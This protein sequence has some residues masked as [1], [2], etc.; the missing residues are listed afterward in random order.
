MRNA[1]LLD[2]KTNLIVAANIIQ[3]VTPDQ[4]VGVEESWRVYRD[5]AKSKRSREGVGLPEHNHWRW[6]EKALELKFTAYR[7][8]AV[9]HNNEIQGLTMLSTL[10]VSGRSAVHRGK[11]VL[12]VKYI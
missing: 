6:D 3:N 12:Y 1:R 4:L 7:C 5:A 8:L 11:P 10:A 2:R 9:S